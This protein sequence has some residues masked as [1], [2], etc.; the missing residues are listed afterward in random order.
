MFNDLPDS[1]ASTSRFGPKEDS[2]K[3]D[4][5][6]LYEKEK[7]NKKEQLLKEFPG[8]F[9]DLPKLPNFKK[10]SKIE[11]QSLIQVKEDERSL[12]KFLSL[13]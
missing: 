1:N 10:K 2:K 3:I 12:D 7:I 9:D 8:F 5:N 6:V 4:L 11:I 13:N